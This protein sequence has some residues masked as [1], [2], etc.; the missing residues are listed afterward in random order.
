MRMATRSAFLPAACLSGSIPQARTTRS[1]NRRL[2][3]CPGSMDS[4]SR[5]W[6]FAANRTFSPSVIGHRDHTPDN[7]TSLIPRQRGGTRSTTRHKR[8]RPRGTATRRCPHPRRLLCRVAA[9][10]TELRIPWLRRFKTCRCCILRWIPAWEGIPS[11]SRHNL[12][13]LR[14]ALRFPKYHSY[15]LRW[16]LN[17]RE[18]LGKWFPRLNRQLIHVGSRH[19]LRPVPTPTRVALRTIQPTCRPRP[20]RR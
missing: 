12:S 20:R 9:F 14:C 8:P 1:Q 5:G 19:R 18:F 11:R 4:H 3:R 6:S 10:P 13:I 15:I 16:L 7:S 17:R 2:R